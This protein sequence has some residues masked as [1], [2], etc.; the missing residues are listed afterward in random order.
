[1]N[2]FNKSKSIFTF[3]A[4]ITCSQIMFVDSYANA[5]PYGESIRGIERDANTLIDYG[6]RENKKIIS[7]LSC[8]ELLN[9]ASA[10]KRNYYWWYQQAQNSTTDYNRRASLNSAK[11]S[12]DAINQYM[13][14]YKRRKC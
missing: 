5:N 8:Q 3:A 4:Y 2:L 11:G 12:L 14:E 9:R 10:K 13:S 7:R 1:M 6:K